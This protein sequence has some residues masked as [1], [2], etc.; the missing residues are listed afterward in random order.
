MNAAAFAQYTK[1]WPLTLLWV[2][3]IN[4]AIYCTK[5]ISLFFV[6]ETAT[7]FLLCGE[8]NFLGLSGKQ[9]IIGLIMFLK[10]KKQRNMQFKCADGSVFF[11]WLGE[12]IALHT[13]TGNLLF[14]VALIKCRW[15]RLKLMS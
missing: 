7:V 4:N 11:T 10:I 3:R 6:Q 13:I 1:C 2:A 14:F 15:V 12:R 5:A 9:A 8:I